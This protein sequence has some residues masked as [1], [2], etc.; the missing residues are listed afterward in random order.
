MRGNNNPYKND[1]GVVSI[2]VTVVVMLVLS[3]IVLT[4]ARVARREQRQALDRQLNTQA[5]YA[6]EAGINDA[7]DEL[8]DPAS[9]FRTNE[10]NNCDPLPGKTKELDGPTGAISYSC[11]LIDPTPESF[12]YSS[13]SAGEA[14]VAKI[15]R[16]DNGNINQIAIYWQDSNENEK[17][18]GCPSNGNFRT[19]PQAWDNNDCGPGMLRI[20]LVRIPS[21]GNFS[22]DNLTNGTLGTFTAFV[23]PVRRNTYVAN[24]NRQSFSANRGLG[25]QGIVMPGECPTFNAGTGVITTPNSPTRPFHCKI[26]INNMSNDLYY[27][28]ITSLYKTAA[29][30]ICTPDCG[31]GSTESFAAGAGGQVK[32]DATGKVSDVLRRIQIY[33]PLADTFPFPLNAIES[34]DAI[35]KQFSDAPPSLLT[36]GGGS[37]EVPSS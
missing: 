23:S 14:K 30:E 5:F 24:S 17:F 7:L 28:K 19:F 27:L 12:R 21:A 2:V 4:F 31:I 16:Q 37:C 25:G 3:L 26:I 6:A 29:V 9:T 8:K 18:N 15:Q 10:K 34:G 1:D 32:V 22:R 20:D 33:T 35:C 11:V 13:I 36:G